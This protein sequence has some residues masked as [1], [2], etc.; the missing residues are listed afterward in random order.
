[1]G[2]NFEIRIITLPLLSESSKK[3]HEEKIDKICNNLF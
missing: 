2:L 1:M 3:K